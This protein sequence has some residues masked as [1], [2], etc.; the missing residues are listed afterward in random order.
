MG[1]T[2]SPEMRTVLL[3]LG[4]IACVAFIVST[5]CRVI[6]KIIFICVVVLLLNITGVINI[7]KYLPQGS[8]IVSKIEEVLDY[9]GDSEE[10]TDIGVHFDSNV[11]DKEINNG[12]DAREEQEQNPLNWIKSTLG[13]LVDKIQ[14]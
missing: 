10:N 9:K 2:M 14:E 13:S 3:M 4:I 6:T 7:S 5:A 12:G 11:S 1:A 8:S